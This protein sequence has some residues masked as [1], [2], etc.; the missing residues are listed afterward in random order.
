M[1]NLIAKILAPLLLLLY[2]TAAYATSYDVSWSA[3]GGWQDLGGTITYSDG[4]YTITAN[5][6]LAINPPT[7]N[8]SSGELRVYAN[9]TLTVASTDSTPI[10][11]IQ[12]TL[13]PQ[14]IR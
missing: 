14:G 9:G 7:V 5:Q 2:G 6:G 8:A 12:F 4:K 3:D 1:I 11:N 10:R 13:S